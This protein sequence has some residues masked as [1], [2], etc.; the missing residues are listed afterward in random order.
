MSDQEEY[1]DYSPPPQSPVSYTNISVAPNPNA[2]RGSPFADRY[3]TGSVADRFP[4]DPDIPTCLNQ[5]AVDNYRYHPAA[6]STTRAR[7]PHTRVDNDI[8]IRLQEPSFSY[9]G[10]LAA[11]AARE[12]QRRDTQVD[13]TTGRDPH[14]P[15]ASHNNTDFS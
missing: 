8:E 12:N 7:R 5:L 1:I 3:S 13:T 4:G 6:A 11:D 10:R 2:P 9:D 15:H 14:D